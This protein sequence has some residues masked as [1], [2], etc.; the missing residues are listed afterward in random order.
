MSA[1]LGGLT[2]GTTYT[3]RLHAA[4]ARG[5]ATGFEATVTT[6]TSPNS[7]QTPPVLGTLRLTTRRFEVGR[8]LTPLA[9]AAP[10]GTTLRFKVSEP[11]TAT[12]EVQRLRPGRRRAGRCLA[13]T[14]ALRR[15]R[16]C[17]R[18]RTFATL[19][20]AVQAGTVTSRSAV[21]LV[22]PTSRD[23]Y[24]PAP[25]AFPFAPPITPATD[26]TR[27]RS[28]SPWSHDGRSEPLSEQKLRAKPM[29][30]AS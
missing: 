16:R 13:P 27:R 23:A 28:A 17:T 2:E 19:R 9:A 25:T 26:Q 8:A 1:T 5:I 22:R 7:D 6:S 20:R 10:R 4:N 15:A 30:S 14:N 24:R 18:A 3:Y 11:G 21:A 12:I 29:A